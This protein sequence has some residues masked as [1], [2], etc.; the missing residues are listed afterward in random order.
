MNFPILTPPSPNRVPPFR[1]F[2]GGVKTSLHIAA[3]VCEVLCLLLDA[4]KCRWTD[5][6][7]SATAPPLIRDA[8]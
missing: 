4:G 3:A 6:T 5:G 8:L 2:G 1:G 7:F